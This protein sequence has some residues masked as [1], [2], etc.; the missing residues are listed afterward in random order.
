MQHL[1]TLKDCSPEWIA[2]VLDLAAR[3]KA[4]PDDYADA[5]QRKGRAIVLLGEAADRMAAAVGSCVPVI[6]ARAMNQA[7]RL[8]FEAARDGDAVLLSPACSSF[9]MFRSYADRGDRFAE[10]VRELEDLGAARGEP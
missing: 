6:R 2:A 3:L 5:L 8:A 1:V 9:D 10:A 4:R 7:V